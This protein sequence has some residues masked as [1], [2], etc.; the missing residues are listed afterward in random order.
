MIHFK[1]LKDLFKTKKNL[2]NLSD[3]NAKLK[4][5]YVHLVYIKLIIVLVLVIAKSKYISKKLLMSIF[6][7][8]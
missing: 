2:K 8:T 5:M 4:D 1:N 6:Y 7:F 3:T